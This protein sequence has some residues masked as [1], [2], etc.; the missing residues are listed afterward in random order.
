MKEGRNIDERVLVSFETKGSTKNNIEIGERARTSAFHHVH[1][2][3]A[4]TDGFTR[5]ERIFA[6]FDFWWTVETFFPSPE[7][8]YKVIVLHALSH[9]HTHAHAHIYTHTHIQI[10]HRRVSPCTHSRSPSRYVLFRTRWGNEKRRKKRCFAK[11][12]KKPKWR[13]DE[14]NVCTILS[15][16]RGDDCSKEREARVVQL[17]AIPC[18][19]YTETTHLTTTNHWIR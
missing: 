2:L 10:Y 6:G 17:G 4:F 16:M 1:E 5:D 11:F 7:N 19:T 14:F 18:N 12:P 3:C 9:T 13:S 8:M 15:A